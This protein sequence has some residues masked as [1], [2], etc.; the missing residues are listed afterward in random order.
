MI[1][2]KS[3]F[4]KKSFF[5]K[6]RFFSK[7]I[8]FL[9]GFQCKMLDIFTSRKIFSEKI[10]FGSC[11]EKIVIIIIIPPDFFCDLRSCILLNVVK[12]RN[13]RDH[14]FKRIKKSVASK[15]CS[16]FF[17]HYFHIVYCILSL[18]EQNLCYC[19]YEYQAVF[20]IQKES[21]YK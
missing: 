11:S 5:R 13:S 21:S 18:S 1:F 8:D 19:E 4:S 3:I 14:Y 16:V 10:F 6:S 12:S 17:L 9:K 2:E 15:K 7:I 20:A